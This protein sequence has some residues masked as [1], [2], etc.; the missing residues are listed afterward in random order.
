ML[1]VAYSSYQEYQQAFEYLEAR[2]K[3]LLLTSQ[4]ESHYI[5]SK[6]DYLYDN[7]L[8]ISQI[9]FAAFRSYN[10]G[11]KVFSLLSS[12]LDDLAKVVKLARA[13]GVRMEEGLKRRKREVRELQVKI[14]LLEKLINKADNA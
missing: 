1:A 8:E 4:V 5:C 11:D 12:H 14:E 7:L 9:V 6:H 2:L 3:K 10:S 13:D